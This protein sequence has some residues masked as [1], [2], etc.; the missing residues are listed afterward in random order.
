MVTQYALRAMQQQE[1]CKNVLQNNTVDQIDALSVSFSGK[2]YLVVTNDILQG[3][4]DGDSVY[5]KWHSDSSGVRQNDK[6]YCLH[7]QLVT[8]ILSKL[9]LMD[10]SVFK[11]GYT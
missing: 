5:V 9:D 4:R 10:A 2:Y 11:N 1:G 6:N 7:K 3:M 8:F